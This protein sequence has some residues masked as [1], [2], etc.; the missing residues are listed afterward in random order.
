MLRFNGKKKISGAARLVLG[1]ALSI[2][3]SQ[4]AL[5]WTVNFDG[6]AHGHVLN[7]EQV[8]SDHGSAFTG[9]SSGY[10]SSGVGTIPA[11]TIEASNVVGLSTA[12]STSN[13]YFG[14]MGKMT[15]AHGQWEPV[16]NESRGGGEFC[17]P[18]GHLRDSVRKRLGALDILGCADARAPPGASRT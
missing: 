1:V 11:M 15:S 4:G 13:P 7:N 5:A 3:S 10:Y 8:V 17:D 12:V 14:H 9:T 18:F 6:L 16:G 2:G